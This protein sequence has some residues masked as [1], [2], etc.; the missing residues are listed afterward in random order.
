MSNRSSIKPRS[1]LTRLIECGAL[2]AAVMCLAASAPAAQTF[3]FSTG[4]PDGRM[5]TASR[6]ESAGKVEI[7]SADDFVLPSA[8]TVNQATFT[9][10]LPAGL[11]LGD[12]SSVTVEIYRV[13]P[14]DSA[15][16]PDGR[17]PTRV[18]S[19]SDVAFLTRDNSA[20]LSFTTTLLASSFTANN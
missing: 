4:D 11:S 17:V 2:T 15:N 7:E 9:G 16:P 1:P 19:P 13:F 14:N 6:P 18:N 3:F 5:A 10:L 12:V 20:G 8:T